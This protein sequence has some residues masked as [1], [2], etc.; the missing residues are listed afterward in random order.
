MSLL[1]DFIKKLA[2]SAMQKKE[3]IISKQVIRK[4]ADGLNVEFEEL[5]QA[6]F[7]LGFIKCVGS[8]KNIS[9]REC[10][11][12]HATF[13]EFFAAQY[14]SE[15]LYRSDKKINEIIEEH[16]FN[17]FFE[18]IWAFSAGIL[19]KE[20][21]MADK[22]FS[23]L[24][25]EQNM[26]YLGLY[27][28]LLYL[29]CMEEAK[30]KV[31]SNIWNLFIEKITPFFDILIS[32]QFENSVIYHSLPKSEHDKVEDVIIKHLRLCPSL[33]QHQDIRK[34]YEVKSKGMYSEKF[35]KV[36][37]Q[38]DPYGQKILQAVPNGLYLF[39]K[40]E[41]LDF[42][43]SDLLNTEKKNNLIECLLESKAW[44]ASELLSRLELT[45]HEVERLSEIASSHQSTEARGI[46]IKIIA[47]NRYISDV[48]KSDFFYKIILNSYSKNDWIAAFEH[49][50]SDVD[51]ESDSHQKECIAVFLSYKFFYRY[52]LL[53]ALIEHGF[54]ISNKDAIKKL[55]ENVCTQYHP[56]F[57]IFSLLATIRN[58]D[59][60]TIRWL[61]E[62]N[63]HNHVLVRYYV[64]VALGYVST[65]SSY[66][67]I[68]ASLLNEM[69]KK[70]TWLEN[71]W[72]TDDSL[73]ILGT[74]VVDSIR[75]GKYFY[76]FVS[77]SLLEIFLLFT[78]QH[79]Y[80]DYLIY[81]SYFDSSIYDESIKLELFQSQGN[82]I[83]YCN[84]LFRV[85]SALNT[86]VIEAPSCIKLFLIPALKNKV[87]YRLLPII[88]YWLSLIELD[89]SEQ[90]QLQESSNAQ[91]V[92][93][94]LF[95]NFILLKYNDL[96][97]HNIW[98]LLLVPDHYICNSVAEKLLNKDWV[99]DGEQ[100]DSLL[101]AIHNAA[102][103]VNNW[104]LL[105]YRHIKQIDVDRIMQQLI[106]LIT[107]DLTITR[108]SELLYQVGWCVELPVNLLNSLLEMMIC[109]HK[110]DD[111]RL[112]LTIIKQQVEKLGGAE[113]AIR[114]FIMSRIKNI[115]AFDELSV[116]LC[117]KILA[118]L[119]NV[120]SDAMEEACKLIL[121]THFQLDKT[122][123]IITHYDFINNEKIITDLMHTAFQSTQPNNPKNRAQLVIEIM[124]N[125]CLPKN[126]MLRN[127]LL[128]QCIVNS[129]PLNN[130]GSICVKDIEQLFINN[131]IQVLD[132]VMQLI[133]RWC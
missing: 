10:Y 108:Y 115:N 23:A 75:T 19:S 95:I 99:F 15:A 91:D 39:P 46:A 5:Y 57:Q 35:F 3:F 81:P 93:R 74:A 80:N 120:S 72:V 20:Y 47:D 113:V 28:L 63:D 11:F 110:I 130:L 17:A 102:L 127:K 49:L 32:S 66:Q 79:I 48:V 101:A 27:P 126:N 4:S 55:R 104:G 37:L 64:V 61:I 69:L 92:Q 106:S 125:Q 16:K 82:I 21:D 87:Y 44:K 89:E 30:L 98:P 31:S 33:C 43:P 41:E 60:E 109:N 131:D 34:I 22:L 76:D 128:C 68:I 88:S 118:Y 90:T 9:Q 97:I 133:M 12:I 96:F 1:L 7:D 84:F 58:H 103:S 13:Q 25:P 52:E 18:E 123:E 14:L 85:Y 119:R 116:V 56:S 129:I 38:I 26:E 71:V 83:L 121:A 45:D 36:L 29:R 42:L 124:I 50:I 24:L 112:L 6:A 100:V 59:E 2:C 111:N 86:I 105:F 94:S 67:H 132:K 122:I 70:Q 117:L 40:T 73:K 51:W 114:K 53:S 107:G 77:E 62:L 8:Q 65:T 54:I 78:N